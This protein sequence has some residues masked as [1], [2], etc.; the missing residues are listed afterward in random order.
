MKIVGLP[1]KIENGKPTHFMADFRPKLLGPDSFPDGL[2]VDTS[3]GIP[4]PMITRIHHIPEKENIINLSHLQS[5]LLF[6]GTQISIYPDFPPDISEQR[7]A[8]HGVKKKLREAGI[9]HGLL[10][11]ARLIL[12]LGSKQNI[13]LKPFDGEMFH[14]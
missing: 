8:F 14:Q 1:E 3:A 11:P 5:P 10:F 13:Y 6:N 2:K 9:K 4:S 12:T 7:W